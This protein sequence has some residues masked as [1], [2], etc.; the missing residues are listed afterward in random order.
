MPAFG[1]QTRVQCSQ[2]LAICQMA[3][4]FLAIWQNFSVWGPLIQATVLAQGSFPIGYVQLFFILYAQQEIWGNQIKIKK[5][6]S[7]IPIIPSP[8]CLTRSCPHAAPVNL[9]NGKPKLFFWHFSWEKRWMKLVETVAQ[10]ANML[11]SC[12]N[13]MKMKTCL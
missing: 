9:C 5:T 11:F 2:I 8:V 6:F 4:S 13:E 12:I 7:G 1:S 10:K 3:R